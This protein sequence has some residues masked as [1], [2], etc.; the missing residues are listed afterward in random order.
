[1]PYRLTL[2]QNLPNR[3][4]SAMNVNYTFRAAPPASWPVTP[5]G[6]PPQDTNVAV[7]NCGANLVTQQNVLS[8][9][10]TTHYP[11]P[12]TDVVTGISSVQPA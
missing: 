5:V 7:V 6:A 3:T 4:P 2:V 1:M 8:R 12:P 10:L 9:T 11:T